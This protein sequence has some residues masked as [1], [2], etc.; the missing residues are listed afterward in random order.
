MNAPVSPIILSDIESFIDECNHRDE[1]RGASMKPATAKQETMALDRRDGKMMLLPFAHP[2]V[3]S[4]LRTALSKEKL[5]EIT[6]THRRGNVFNPFLSEFD[7]SCEVHIGIARLA[8]RSRCSCNNFASD[9][10]I[11]MASWAHA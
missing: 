6:E 11:D 8:C 7:A 4:F 1:L 5:L 10:R 3:F 9:T 2:G